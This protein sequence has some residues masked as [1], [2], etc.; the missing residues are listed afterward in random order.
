MKNYLLTTSLLLFVYF[1]NAQSIPIDRSTP[2]AAAKNT[3]IDVNFN[4][5]QGQLGPYTVELVVLETY[6]SVFGGT[7]FTQTL[8]RSAATSSTNTANISIGNITQTGT[9]FNTAGTNFISYNYYL[10]AYT[11]IPDP[12]SP[13][14]PTF[15]YYLTIK[16][17]SEPILG[18]KSKNS[19]QYYPSG[20]TLQL[21]MVNGSLNPDNTFE[22]RL[23]RKF[24]FNFNEEEFIATLPVV[25]QPGGRLGL[26][27]NAINSLFVTLPMGLDNNELGYRIQ[28]RSTSPNDL[29]ELGLRIDNSIPLPVTLINF[30]ANSTKNGNLLQWQTSAE[31]NFSHF[32]VERSADAKSFE[33]IGKVVGAK[34][35]KEKLLYTFIDNYLNSNQLSINQSN[36]TTNQSTEL[37][38]RTT[39]SAQGMYYRLKMLDLDGKYEYSKIIFINNNS[40]AGIKVFPNPAFDYINIENMV[41]KNLNI[42]I[43]DALGQEIKNIINLSDSNIKISVDGI[44][45]GAYFLQINDGGKVQYKKV[46]VNK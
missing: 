45:T 12:I 27:I 30:T 42:R 3:S 32:E 7:P 18:I 5:P 34:N 21:E 25:Y 13:Q 14:Q 20:A 43:L 37:T 6:G 36:L 19:Q 44:S 38:G 9:F 22:A 33:M 35:T 28:I 40:E 26:Q 4:P 17:T 46:M 29:D 31:K 23:V 2:F 1:A 8:V 41:G 15:S 11:G 10:R 16:S 24:G 39:V